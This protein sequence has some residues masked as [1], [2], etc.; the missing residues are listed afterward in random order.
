MTQKLIPLYQLA[1]ARTGDKGNRSNIS[2][3]AYR[4]ED[5]E[6]LLRELTVERVAKHFGF[7]VPG[8]IERFVL[9]QLFAMNF[10]IDDVLDGGVNLSLNLD[11]HGKSLSY[12]LLAMDIEVNS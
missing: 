10:V 9:P 6:L 3:I 5:F 8:L 4:P 1:H 11:A 12:W 2:V 7:R